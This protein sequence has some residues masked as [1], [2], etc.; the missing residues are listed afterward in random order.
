[1]LGL[2]TK[3]PPMKNSSSTYNLYMASLHVGVIVKSTQKNL[4]KQRT[5][6]VVGQSFIWVRGWSVT[7]QV[8]MTILAVVIRGG[9][10]RRVCAKKYLVDVAPCHYVRLVVTCSITPVPIQNYT[11]KIESKYVLNTKAVVAIT[12][13]SLL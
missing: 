2:D 3:Y 10:N 13:V 12:L 1:M 8:V 9:P 4:H 6:F 7:S 5:P 11:T